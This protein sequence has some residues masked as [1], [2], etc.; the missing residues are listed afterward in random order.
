MLDEFTSEPRIAY[1]TMEIALR[2]EIPTY[3]GG[4][5]ILA[6]D[7]LRS[8]ADLELPLIGVSLVSRAGYF[9]QEIAADGSQIEHPIFW[10]P[11]DWCAPSEAKVAV[12]IDGNEVWVRGWIYILQ[13]QAG[14]REP[15]LLLDTDLNENRP[16]DREIT[17]YLYG[18][19]EGYRLKQEIILGIG[20]VRLLYALGFQIRQFHMNE[21]HSALLA[22]ELLRR[23]AYP[24]LG[25]RP[26]E[27]PYDIPQVRELC[28]F[29]THTPVEAASD[30]LPY[31]LVRRFLGNFIELRILKS[32]AGENNLN[33]TQLALNLSEYVNGVA[34][35]HAEVA[36]KMYPGYHVH[37][38]TNGIHPFTWV[39]PNFSVLYDTHLRGWAH[40]PD[41]LVRADRL[42]DDS[43]WEAHTHAKRVLLDKVNALCATNL[44]PDKP[45]LGF[46]R[47][48]TAYKRPDLLFSNIER[49]KAIASRHPDHARRQGPPSRQRG[50]GADQAAAS[51]YGGTGRRYS[52]RLPAQLRYGDCPVHGRRRGRVAQYAAAPARSVRYQRHEGGAQWRAQ[53]ERAGRLVDRRL[54]RGRNRLGRMR[55]QRLLG[56]RRCGISL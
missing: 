13:S 47:R 46:A 24:A 49:L 40:E 35:R 29:T 18:G 12:E 30:R 51:P 19:D 3:S 23:H 4:L 15:V 1:F 27:S 9:R 6:G 44:D 7:T 42:P 28:N 26:G 16:E 25:V 2:N 52:H 45:I 36:G 31:D 41:Y 55:Q 53:S 20:G 8:S 22:L 10:E 33:M 37:A 54:D 14:G 17:H 43:V 32:L 56:K 39:C 5:G 50:K 34:Q 48:M 38:I 11:R 21:G